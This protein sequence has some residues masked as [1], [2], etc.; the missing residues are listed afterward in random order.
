MSPREQ[1]KRLGLER[2]K[3]EEGKKMPSSVCFAVNT[4][5]FS[6]KL[7]PEDIA[8]L[9]KKLGVDGVEW[10]LPEDLEKAAKA[11]KRMVK[12]S[13]DNGLKVAAF[14]NGG[15]LWEIDLMRRWSDIVAPTGVKMLR[16]TSAWVA[17]DFNESLHQRDSIVDLVKRTRDG[18]ANLVPLSHEY[19]IRYVVEMHMGSTVSNACLARQVCEGLDPSAVG[20]I[21]DPANGVYEGHLRPRHALELLGPYLAY[22]HA[23]NLIWQYTGESAPITNINRAH[24]QWKTTPL[25]NGIIDWVEVCFALNIVNFNGWISMEEFFCN[26]PERGIANGLSFLRDCVEAA[27]KKLERP[28]TQF[29]D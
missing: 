23:K 4:N 18:M 21:Y 11:A 29:N 10:G 19:G 24:W 6:E 17:F 8:S 25:A 2:D 1:V 15:K 9:L 3:A 20:I 28:F 14:I 5:V 13:R 16:V 27:P 22:V 26:D 12:A 7:T